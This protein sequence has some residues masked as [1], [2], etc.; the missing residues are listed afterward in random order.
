MLLDMTKVAAMCLRFMVVMDDVHIR[1]SK[2]KITIFFQNKKNRNL[3]FMHTFCVDFSF[4]HKLY[5]TNYNT[6]IN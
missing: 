3:D 5:F 6:A 2:L 4:D 1:K